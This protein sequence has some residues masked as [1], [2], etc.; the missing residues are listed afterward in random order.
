MKYTEE[1]IDHAWTIAG[2]ALRNRIEELRLDAEDHRRLAREA[3]D[4]A[5]SIERAIFAGRWWELEKIIGKENTEL[6]CD[7][8]PTDRMSLISS[9]YLADRDGL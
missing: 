1:E 8:E 9:E 5:R 2:C 3:E 7:V 4:Y 6:L